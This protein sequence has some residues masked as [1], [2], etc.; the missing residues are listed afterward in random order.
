WSRQ[1]DGPR[2]ARPI[3]RCAGVISSPAQQ[4]V[5]G[6]ASPLPAGAF[7]LGLV[8]LG[9]GIAEAE[10][11]DESPGAW[12]VEDL[13]HARRIENRYPTHADAL[14]ACRE[15]HHGDRRHQ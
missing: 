3:L 10:I 15:P 4:P 2:F 1:G 14:C 8:A 12:N 5:A 7:E 11:A 13:V 6:V 9:L